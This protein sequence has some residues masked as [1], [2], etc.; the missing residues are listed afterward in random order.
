MYIWSGFSARA[1][2]SSPLSLHDKDGSLTSGKQS[3]SLAH[4]PHFTLS[5][6][7]RWLLLA[8]PYFP[9]YR[10]EKI[11]LVYLVRWQRYTKDDPSVF[12]FGAAVLI[13]FHWRFRWT[14]KGGWGGGRGGKRCS[15][16]PPHC[17]GW[18][19]RSVCSLSCSP[20]CLDLLLID[21]CFVN[22]KRS[23]VTGETSPDVRAFNSTHTYAHNFREGSEFIIYKDCCLAEVNTNEDSNV[24]KKRFSCYILWVNLRNSA[25]AQ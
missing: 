11:P 1:V 6:R 19:N 23:R 3:E 10:P 9:R 17:K 16:L 4:T 7:K 12:L 22:R 20:S 24:L 13:G 18:L 8:G 15:N 2:L 5:W 14:W 21:S 25:Q